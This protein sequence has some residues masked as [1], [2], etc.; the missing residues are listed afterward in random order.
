MICFGLFSS[1]T[2]PLKSYLEDYC[3]GTVEASKV[4]S[5][6]LRWGKKVLRYGPFQGAE[7][8][9]RSFPF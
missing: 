6:N 7:L 5:Y 3:K 2:V 9:P 4:L 8:E 1:F